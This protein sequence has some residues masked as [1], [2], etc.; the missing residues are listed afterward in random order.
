MRDI[1]LEKLETTSEQVTEMIEF[2]NR[3]CNYCTERGD[4]DQA[5]HWLQRAWDLI[6]VQHDLK[7]DII[8]IKGEV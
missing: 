4:H 3:M 7:H 2:Y 1:M 5:D 6:D 8:T